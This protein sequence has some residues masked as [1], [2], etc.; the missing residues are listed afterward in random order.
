MSDFLQTI[1]IETAPQPEA[2]VIW[3]HGLG[4]D[5]N[6]FV[7][8]VDELDLRGMPALRFVFPNAP[9]R[10]VTINGGMVMRA[11]YDITNLEFAARQEDEPG[12]RDSARI[13]SRLIARENVRGIME[14]RI[15][16]AG[17]S[18]GGAIVLHGGLRHP[19]RLAGILA[20]STYLPLAATLA[21][22]SSAANRDTPIFMAHG[23][24][25]AVIPFAAA[26]RSQNQLRGAQYRIEWHE[27][28]M[29]H[30]VCV[31]EIRDLNAWLRACLAAC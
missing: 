1:E 5:G 17:F 14:A 7:P 23:A 28:P 11:W 4:A 18:Q 25:D 16:V 8:I 22:E 20:L 15:V 10:P 27:Y 30:A 6:D 9:M 12:I 19:A 21:A 24:Q 31:E 29:D 26:H 3:L 2:A 13:L